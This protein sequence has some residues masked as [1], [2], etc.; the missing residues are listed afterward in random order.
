MWYYVDMSLKINIY[1][2]SEFPC[3]KFMAPFLIVD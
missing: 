1:T 3:I 2:F